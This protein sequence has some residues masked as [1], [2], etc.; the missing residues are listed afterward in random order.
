MLQSNGIQASDL[1]EDTR[2]WI[3]EYEKIEKSGLPAVKNKETGEFTPAAVAKLNRINRAI[4]DGI[5]DYLTD[6]EEK[7]EAEKARLEEEERL[8]LEEEA[9]RNPPPPPPPPPA[10][11]KEGLFDWLGF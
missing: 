11:K 3:K 6:K 9:R 1:D 5:A 4:T 8:R 7:D 10:P 2:A